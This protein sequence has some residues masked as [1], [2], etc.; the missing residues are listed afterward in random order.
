MVSTSGQSFFR[1]TLDAMSIDVAEPEL[2]ISRRE[3]T[4]MLRTAQS[5]AVPRDAVFRFFADPANLGRITPPEMRF[6]I[7]TP[8]PIEMRVGALID[9][10]IGLWALPLRWRTRIS[11]WNPPLGFTDE[12]LRG[13][14][15][16]WVHQHRFVATPDGGTR[17]DDVV[18]FRLPLGQLGRI[19]APLVTGQLRRIFAYRHQAI[20]AVFA[21]KQPSGRP[22]GQ[23]T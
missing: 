18:T 15:A 9:Y 16:E 22:G 2:I 6:S 1:R 17:V 10:R 3:L 20:G 19:A 11:E 5:L 4:W 13:P 7:V 21:T 8:E 23:S 12:Q 14:Y